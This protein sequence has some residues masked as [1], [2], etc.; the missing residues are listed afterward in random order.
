MLVFVQNAHRYPVISGEITPAV[1]LCFINTSYFSVFE[2]F[3]IN[4][5]LQ[6]TVC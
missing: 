6:L 1:T 2:E 4:L 3:V 5:D